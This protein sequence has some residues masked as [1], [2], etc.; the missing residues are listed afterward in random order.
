MKSGKH[1]PRALIKI[2]E[3]I[4]IA[5]FQ[6]HQL[7]IFDWYIACIYHIKK[8]TEKS[9]PTQIL[10]N[11]IAAL[12]HASNNQSAANE[13]S[14]EKTT[15]S[16]FGEDG[17]TFG[18][19]IDIINPLQHIPIVNSIY[20]KVT[21]DVIAPAM[22]IAGGALFGGPIGAALS[23][24]TNVFKSQFQ[25]DVKSIELDSPYLDS[26]VHSSTAIATNTSTEKTI[27]TEDYIAQEK[28]ATK[29][30]DYDAVSPSI[31]HNGILSSENIILRHNNNISLNTLHKRQAYQSSDGIMA[32]VYQNK[33]PYSDVVTSTD[34]PKKK[35]DIIIGSTAGAG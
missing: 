30:T 33:E 13:L 9:L 18:D 31:I 34:T 5:Y 23:V 1:L 20:R 14:P 24:V 4:A 32:L 11:G 10:Q 21:G 7:S 25:G 6:R 8:L 16:I 3:T 35:I 28:S 12:L 17:F 19:I 15:N 26:D 22:E 27:S 29:Q 2:I